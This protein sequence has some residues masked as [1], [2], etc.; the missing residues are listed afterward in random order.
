M[1]TSTEIVH[2]PFHG[3]DLLTIEVDGKPHIFLRPAVEAIGLD[4]S[5][6]LA[7][8]R[9]RSWACVGSCPMQLPGDGQS[10]SYTTV[11]V[12]TF[13]MLLAT[14]D[15]RRV[16]EHVRPLLI[17]YQ[18]EVAD[19]IEAYWTDGVAVRDVVPVQRAELSRLE[20]IEI[21][22]SAELE[23][24]ALAQQ[25]EELAPA[26]RAW[27]TLATADG[28]YSVADAAKVLTRDPSIKVGR[29]RLFTV[30]RQLKWCYRQ[31]IDGRHRAYQTAIECGRLSELPSSHYHPR[32]GELILDPPQARVTVKGL[33]YLHKQLG[34][35]AP[36]DATSRE[37]LG[38][39][40]R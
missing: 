32:T 35:T 18:S 15:E 28:D 30:L 29:D 16:A 11:D 13:L 31:E 4:F 8:L 5:S 2:V 27:E 1:S 37:L 24:L 14:V 38:G 40:P 22:R 21:A 20:L 34:G 33:L 19:A 36:L 23:R 3:T 17:A 25:V 39:G 26:A 9:S 12:R 6:Q 7:K 10:R